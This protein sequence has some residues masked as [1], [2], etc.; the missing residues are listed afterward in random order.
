MVEIVYGIV[1]WWM[2]SMDGWVNR[3]MCELLDVSFCQK[4][5][6]WEKSSSDYT[7]GLRVPT[8]RYLVCRLHVLLEKGFVGLCTFSTR[9]LSCYVQ[10]WIAIVAILDGFKL[11]A[12]AASNRSRKAVDPALNEKPL[13][14][15]RWRWGDAMRWIPIYV[16][17]IVYTSPG[18]S[19]VTISWFDIG[20]QGR[21]DRQ[22]KYRLSWVSR[23]VLKYLTVVPAK[24]DG[25]TEKVYGT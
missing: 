11:A 3:M 21:T 7:T 25:Q 18:Y 22:T 24:T 15:S 5:M 19:Y 14:K 9:Y 17:M 13:A 8:T 2:D 1:N 12:M 20:T 23:V 6:S 16:Y 10:H 4:S